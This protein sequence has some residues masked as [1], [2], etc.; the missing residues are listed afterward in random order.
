[1]KNFILIV[2]FFLGGHCFAQS[3]NYEKGVLIVKV[4]PRYESYFANNQTDNYKLER[5]FDQYQVQSIRKEYP[6]S[7]R[8]PESTGVNGVQPADISRIYRVKYSAEKEPQALVGDFLQTGVFVYAEPSFTFELL[9]TPDDPG[10]VNQWFL[11]T[12]NAFEAWDVSKGDTDVVIGISDTGFDIDHPDLVNSVKYN[13]SDTI[14]GVDNDGDGY[15][16]N[17]RGWDLGDNDN[18]PSVGG[19]WHGIFV[20]GVA[21][22]TTDNTNQLAGVGFNCKLLPLKINN[23]AGQ[24]IGAYQSIVYAAD[25]GVDVINCSWGSANSWSQQGQDVVTYAT[26]NKNCLVVA[27]A[28]NNNDEGVFYPASFDFVLS[29]GGIDTS[30]QKWVQSVGEGSNYNEY[31]DLVAPAM[32]IMRIN[33]NGGTLGNGRGTSFSAPMVAGAAGLL[34]SFSPSLTAVQIMLQ[35]K[36][37]ANVSIYD[38]PFNTAYQDKLGKGLLDMSAAVTDFSNP[39]FIFDGAVFTDQGDEWFVA[40]DTV[41]MFGSIYNFLASSSASTKISL[42]CYSPYIKLIDSTFTLGAIVSGNGGSTSSIPFKFEMQPGIPVNEEVTF[43]VLME[44][45]SYSNWQ[46]LRYVF[47]TNYVNINEN[48]IQLSVSSSGKIG[49]VGDPGDQSIGVGVKHANGDNL[50]YQM[51]VM[52]SLD[53]VKTSFGLDGDFNEERFLWSEIGKGPDYKLHSF[54][55]DD[56]AGTDKIGISVHQKTMAWNKAELSDFIIVELNIQNNSGADINGLSMGLFSDWDITNASTNVAVYDSI[57]RTGYVY[58]AGG[59]YAGVHVLSDSAVQHYAFDNN[60]SNGSINQYDGFSSGEQSI[61]ILN[62]NLRDSAGVGDVSHTVGVGGLNIPN[63][64]SLVVAF[65]IVVGN[66]YSDIYNA[67]LQ[68]DT[69][70]FNLTHL[71]I[72]SIYA[73]KPNCYADCDGAVAVSASGGGGLLTYTWNDVGASNGDTLNGVCAGTYQVVVEDENGLKD[74]LALV[75]SDQLPLSINITDTIMDLGSVCQGEISASVTGGV[76]PYAVAWNDDLGRDSLRAINLCVGEYELTITDN[77]GCAI[78]D[79]IS[80]SDLVNVQEFSAGLRGSPN[81]A[82]NKVYFNYSYNS[83][84]TIQVFNQLGSKVGEVNNG[85]HMFS[86]EYL[87]AG[88]YFVQFIIENQLFTEKIVVLK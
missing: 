9:Y 39:G 38:I 46:M 75:L 6:F 81:P 26:V 11:D 49:F 58:N 4:K 27:S 16:D 54:Y 31:V 5:V 25:H 7:A 30:N 47:N 19:N 80:I 68:S 60:G 74:S 34:K 44:D 51:G 62:G 87:P 36:A 37:S 21:G 88:N 13:Y 77:N 73:Q 55:N 20:A 2:A 57:M 66:N 67:S 83:D 86:F 56:S 59:K 40:G 82:T 12:I 41:S 78:K 72:D 23:T 53:A 35:L 24:L 42:V 64:D 50:L 28:G 33:N 71:T 14:D 15:I 65:A 18:N 1:M 43:K 52:A 85:Q 69:T 63:G 76:L 22:A 84:L 17:Y 8:Q 32:D 61:S 29:V 45:G 70:Y 10:I 3:P 48:N 79:T